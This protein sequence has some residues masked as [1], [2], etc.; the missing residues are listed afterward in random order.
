MALNCK[1]DILKFLKSNVEIKNRILEEFKTNENKHILKTTSKK[2]NPYIYEKILEISIT[3]FMF[4]FVYKYMGILFNI[5]FFKILSSPVILFFLG[6]II[7]VLSLLNN[8]IQKIKF[9]KND[10]T[11]SE[12]R[13]LIKEIFYDTI[14]SSKSQMNQKLKFENTYLSIDAMSIISEYIDRETFSI[15]L[16]DKLTYAEIGII[17]EIEIKNELK[18]FEERKLIVEMS[19]RKERELFEKKKM[20]QNKKEELLDF[21]YKE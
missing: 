8:Y 12:F 21:L 10:S 14:Q 18:A 6:L 11:F 1:N 19:R 20:K 7:L 4:H 2:K 9:K 5:D 16:D 15:I 13:F 3:M 17:N